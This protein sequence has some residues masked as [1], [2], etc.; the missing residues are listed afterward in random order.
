MRCRIFVAF[1]SL[2]ATWTVGGE[3]PQLMTVL[4]GPGVGKSIA[5]LRLEAKFLKR[6]FGPGE[7]LLLVLKTNNEGATPLELPKKKAGWSD[8]EFEVKRDGKRIEMPRSRKDL[9][10]KPE[11]M[12]LQPGSSDTRCLDLRALDWA[13]PGWADELGTYEV[14]VVYVPKQ[15]RSGWTSFR[16]TPPGE[17]LPELAPER[18]ELLRTCIARL[19]STDPRER[20]EAYR[21]IVTFGRPALLMLEQAAAGADPEIVRQ[22]RLAMSEI[23]GENK[24]NVPVVPPPPIQIRPIPPP[25]QPPV[26]PQ[27]PLPPIDEF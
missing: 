7:S 17:T 24:P 12:V 3:N 9:A 4:P 10:I 2:T 13:N 23:R 16:I 11:G 5:G 26:Q 1:L 15:L 25:P 18:A 27:P 6:D 22:C 20:R 21:Q 14:A 8:Y 19:G